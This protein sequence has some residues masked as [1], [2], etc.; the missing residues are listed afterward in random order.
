VRG[1][2]AL[3]PEERPREAEHGVKLPVEAVSRS[4]AADRDFPPDPRPAGQM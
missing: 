2:P 1:K 3:P 4:G